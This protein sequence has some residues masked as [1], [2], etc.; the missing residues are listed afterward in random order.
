MYELELITNEK[1]LMT[2]TKEKSQEI[3]D[4]LKYV[5]NAKQVE[6]EVKDTIEKAMTKI[7]LETGQ[8]KIESKFVNVAYIPATTT[9]KFD[10]KAFKEDYPELYEKYLKTSSKKQSIRITTYDEVE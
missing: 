7:Y 8:T 1:D 3:K 2:F 5:E 10:E 6:K 4:L 9:T